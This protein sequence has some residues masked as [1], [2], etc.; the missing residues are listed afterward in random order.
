M[1][2]DELLLQRLEQA[3]KELLDIGNRNRLVNTPRTS[4]R[5]SRVEIVGEQS[6][7][8]FRLLVAEGKALTFRAT[9]DEDLEV[10]DGETEETVEIVGEDAVRSSA[11]DA[12]ASEPDSVPGDSANLGG[13]GQP[14]S[15]RGANALQTTMTAEVLDRRLLKLYYDA[16][17]FEEE[18]GVSALYLALGFLKWYEDERSDRARFA[19]LLLIPVALERSAAGAQFRLRYLDDDITTNLS[20]QARLQS[21]GVELPE[22][23][24]AEDLSPEAYFGKVREAIRNQNRWE[25]LGDDI[26]LWFFSFSKFLMYRDLQP[27]N[28]P[29]GRPLEQHALVGGMLGEGFDSEPPLCGDD[30][31]VDPLLDPAET[32]HVMDADSSQ[33][34]AIEEVRRG[35]N[36]VVQGPPGTGK[37]QTIANLIAAAVREGKKVLFVA[38]K[39]A[40]LDVVKR[41]LD[42]VGLGDMCLELHSHKANKKAVLEELKR[43]LALGRPRIKGVARQV[44]ELRRCRDPLNRHADLLHAPLEPA[45]ITPYQALGKLV[46][47]RTQGVRPAKFRLDDATRWSDCDY[48]DKLDLLTDLAVHLRE[49]EEPATHPWRGVEVES[50]LPNDLARLSESLPTLLNRIDSL[51]AAAGELAQHL[52][53]DAGETAIE[54][55]RLAQFANRLVKAPVIDRRQIADACWSEARNDI[56]RLVERGES[57]AEARRKLDGVVA[58]VAWDTPVTVARRELAAHGRSWFRIFNRGYRE[59]QALL[60]GIVVDTPPKPLEERVRLLDALLAGQQAR[61]GVRDGAELGR[62]AFGTKWEGEESDWSRLRAVLDWENDC[63]E[64]GLPDSFREA[65]AELADPAVLSDLI[66]IISRN[67]KPLLSELEPIIARLRWNLAAAFEVADATRIPL[68]E[69]RERLVAWQAAP[70]E[71]TKWIA[72]HRRFR[73]LSEAGLGGV[74][75]R[76]D[77]GAIGAAELLERFEMA[78]CEEMAREAFRRHPDLAEFDG[79]SHEQLV[80]K[81]RELDLGRIELAR[82]EV[83]LAHY[84]GIPKG[85]GSIGEMGLLMHEMNKK[86]RHLPLRKLLAGAGHAVQAIKPVF[87][88]SPLSLAQFLEPGVIEFDLLLIDEAS[89]VQPVDALGA[90]ARARQFVVVGDDKQLPPTRFF[91]KLMD[92]GSEADAEELHAADMES[93]LG[94]CRSRGVLS[95]MLR[96]HYRSRHH[97]LIA[98]SNREFYDSRLFII[99]SPSN[100]RGSQGLVF[101]HVADGLF[102]RGGSA[103]NAVEARLVAEKVIEHARLFPDKSLGVG[104][105]SVAQRDAVLDE[106]ELLRR[107]HP[108]LESFFVTGGGEPFFVK[109]L[110]N[111]QGDERDVIFISVGYGKDRDG[112]MTMNFGPL[113]NDGGERR[114]N[115]LISRAKERCEVFSSI[116]AD[117]IDLGRARA[118]GVRALKTFLKYAETGILELPT[119]SD[120]DHDSEFERE[121]KTALETHGYDV[122]RQVG[123]AGFFIDLAVVDPDLPGRY[124]LGIECDGAT[125]HSSRSARDRDRLRQQL[126]EDRRWIIHRI[127]STDWFHRPDE[128]LRKTLEAIGRAKSEL[129]RRESR[130]APADNEPASNGPATIDRDERTDDDVPLTSVETVPYTEASFTIREPRD[131]HAT[132]VSKLAKIVIRV[133]EIEGPVHRE[134]IARRISTLW[135]LRRTGNRIAAAIDDALAWSV[136]KQRLICEED[137]FQLADGETPI[138]NRENVSS[139]SLRQ[140]D[141]LPPAELRAAVLAVVQAHRGAPADEVAVEVTRLLGFR[142]TGPQLRE[143]VLREIERLTDST[144]LEVRNGKLYPSRAADVLEEQ[145]R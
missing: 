78:Y 138:R 75:A 69:L 143:T 104:T 35:R 38:E 83:L 48:H 101:H 7:D 129:I 37:S 19:P 20:L 9:R 74:A 60:R 127:W 122:H 39:M 31:K 120:R 100:G 51:L 81:F 86:R 130:T 93:I 13:N 125:Y 137:F 140:A 47:L 105:F 42:N 113:S 43:T 52:K 135:G 132:P 63:R 23:P 49:I 103:T 46:R 55:S 79:N 53:C 141:R 145:S 4:S 68:S 139:P 54:I 59:A 12:A 2:T 115:V 15:R 64:S 89:Q 32:T 95:R 65:F 16:R 27:E 117:D 57:L 144:R 126:L 107:E 22:V 136:K 21:F 87:L 5:S 6:E 109:N 25:V 70:E 45:R 56:E 128:Q 92:D 10:E 62:R 108:E 112:R 33:A 88:M 133:V 134:E 30:D 97:S 24:D 8:V 50:I 94:L 61:K 106:L 121:V 28:W 77:E 76:I 131:L 58:E 72:Y 84:E 66:G 71:V 111:I 82:R 110:E 14:R 80:R 17:T 98:V 40:A 36:L 73:R 41:R 3:R 96:W 118:V 90:F 99:P 142:Q 114:L 116:R 18:Q 29:A 102:D 44:E 124:L 34:I 123:E 119:L 26:V 85:S 11:E 67:L 91:Q 1:P